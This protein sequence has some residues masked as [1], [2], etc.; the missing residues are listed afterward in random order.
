MDNSCD[1]DIILK[2]ILSRQRPCAQDILMT[3]SMGDH[4]AVI[5]FREEEWYYEAHA[6]K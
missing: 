6:Q 1:G 3:T 5:K 4:S 2:K